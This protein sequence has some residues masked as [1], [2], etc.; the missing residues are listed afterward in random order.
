MFPDPPDDG[1]AVFCQTCESWS[2]PRSSC[3]RD[4]TH[5]TAPLAVMELRREGPMT[6]DEFKGTS[7][8]SKRKHGIAKLELTA[9]SRGTESVFG[10][11]RSIYYIN[12]EHAAKEVLNKW[13]SENEDVLKG[14]ELTTES[15]TRALSKQKFLKAWKQLREEKEFKVLSHPDRNDRG[16]GQRKSRGCPYCGETIK[17]LP[18]HLP[19]C[20][21][22]P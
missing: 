3:A 12:N 1:N 7:Y 8:E 15:I 4:S 6:G 10:N 16:G 17:R 21:Q 13:I 14:R 2:H 9:H 22:K 11:T 19:D 18:T 5:E 20:D